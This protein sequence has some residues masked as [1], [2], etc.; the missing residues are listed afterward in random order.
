MKL[1]QAV[2]VGTT[3][4]TCLVGAAH[5]GPK[6][7]VS[8]GEDAYRLLRRAGAD[9]E[10]VEVH[11]LPVQAPAAEGGAKLVTRDQSVYLMQVNADALPRLSQEVHQRL[12][13]CA[14]YVTH[15]S[16]AQGRQ[17]LASFRAALMQQPAGKVNYEIDNQDEVNALLPQLQESNVRST[18]VHL[19]TDYKNR[20]YSTHYGVNASDDLVKTWKALAAGRDD[21]TVKQFSHSWPQ[22][23]VI[24]TI[25]GTT[26]P[27]QIVV[28]GGHLDSTIGNTQEESIAPGADDDASGIAS[29]TEVAR[30]LLSSGYKPRRTIQFM[31]YAAEEIGLY[32][33]AAIAADYKAQ[34][35]KVIGALQ[36]DMTNYQGGSSDYTMITDYTNA[37]QNTFVKNLAAYYTPSMVVNQGVCG[38][39]CSDHASW[40]RN[41]YVASFPF[42]SLLSQDNP[43]IHTPQDTI[44]KSG[45]NA[46]H[47]I[48]FSRLALAFAVELGSDGPAPLKK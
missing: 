16:R 27:K 25:K 48:K 9:I 7:W 31:A 28:I 37:A 8:V 35:K 4:A 42:E 34:G 40:T 3:L 17:E 32:G 5:A 18:I 41:G 12:N 44:D 39:A 6:V 26:R 15:T 2:W 38:Y 11:S 20:Y 47:A 23:S 24:M 14:G 33:S 19:S 43:Y 10:Q 22:K 46:N 45:N 21:V 13:R 1:R 30:V 29:L 36:L